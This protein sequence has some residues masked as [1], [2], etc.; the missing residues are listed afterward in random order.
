MNT[1]RLAG[2]TAVAAVLATTACMPA[3]DG[4]PPATRVFGAEGWGPLT[5]GMSKQEALA[6]GELS[7]EPLAVIAGCDY[8]SFTNGPTP[9]PAALA[10]DQ[11]NDTA[12]RDA[13]RRVED[14]TTRIGP[15]PAPDA[16]AAD[17]LSWASRSAD[18]ALA[19]S[20]AAVMASSTTDRIAQLVGPT[21]PTG[22]VSFGQ[23]KLRLIGAPKTARTADGIGQGSSLTDLRKTYLG[24]GLGLTSP[25]RY[26]MPA[27][28]Q[29]GWMLD[30]DFNPTTNEVTFVQLRD[31]NAKCL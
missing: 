22:V 5:P 10:A 14:L 24:R 7:P 17:Q 4:G 25:G 6:T 13:V 23:G 3:T 2:L 21:N 19:V 11:A 26:E 15:S 16:P 8:Y 29:A 1:G 27:H 20:A 30:F 31:T 9:D 12:Y 28:G 18:A